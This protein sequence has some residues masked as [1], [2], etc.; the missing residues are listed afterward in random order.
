MMNLTQYLI[1]TNPIPLGPLAC[2][3]PILTEA[4]R[5]GHQIRG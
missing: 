5:D 1:Y 3:L 4:I 2:L